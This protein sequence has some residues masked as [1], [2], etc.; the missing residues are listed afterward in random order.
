M[1]SPK[2]NNQLSNSSY[3][4]SDF[5]DLRAAPPRPVETMEGLRQKSQDG[6]GCQNISETG[7]KVDHLSVKSRWKGANK[8]L[9][10]CSPKMV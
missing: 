5:V 6:D 4:D 1:G 8:H 9:Q 10:T 3:N 7:K 2:F